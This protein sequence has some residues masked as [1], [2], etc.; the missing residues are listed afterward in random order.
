MTKF[1]IL[2][3]VQVRT[4]DGPIRLGPRRIERL[5]LGLLL[6]EAGRTVAADRLVEL[7]WDAT[8]PRHPLRT[9]QAHV[10]RLR[11]CARP[12]TPHNGFRCTRTSSAG[13]RRTSS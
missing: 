3:E 5:L 9:L 6:L 2:G 4:A 13:G 11:A 7:L 12:S 10:S 8:G 1:L